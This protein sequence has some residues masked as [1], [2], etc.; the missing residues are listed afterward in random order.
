MSNKVVVAGAS[1]LIGSKLLNILLLEPRY[2]EVLILVRKEL[3][4]ADKKLVQLVI[5]FDKLD[6]HAA[7]ISGHAIFCCLGSTKK[8]T[9]DLII[10]RKIDHDYPLKLAQL[11]AQTFT[12]KTS[13]L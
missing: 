7:A 3:P 13:Q 1:G 2:D 11:A 10:Y 9:P 12:G 8:K 5:D 6:Q 4:I